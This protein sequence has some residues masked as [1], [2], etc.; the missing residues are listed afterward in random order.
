[1]R[2]YESPAGAKTNQRPSLTSDPNVTTMVTF[3][4][5]QSVLNGSDDMKSPRIGIR[6][7]KMHLSR[8][9]Q[10]VKNGGEVILTDRSKPVGKIVPFQM[11]SPRN[12]CER[13]GMAATDYAMIYAVDCIPIRYECRQ[14][15]KPH[16]M[17]KRTDAESHQIQSDPGRHHRAVA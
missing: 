4:A 15:K 11:I 12:F 16:A 5:T 13:T 17:G 1:M 9:L 2:G 3:D 8:F 10:I 6:E 7:A 14:L